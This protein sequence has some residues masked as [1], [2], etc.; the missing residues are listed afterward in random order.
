MRDAAG[1]GRNV[2]AVLL[3]FADGLQP[4]LCE[5]E[6]VD[7]VAAAVADGDDAGVEPEA[8]EVLDPTSTASLTLVT[9]YPFYYV[10]PAPQ[11]FI[12][13]AVRAAPEEDS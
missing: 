10:G 4:F 6:R 1:Q 8:V 2:G 7:H 9:C 12:V 3:C 13:R 11:R 5:T